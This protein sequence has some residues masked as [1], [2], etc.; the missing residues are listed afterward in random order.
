MSTSP[1]F[2]ELQ[3]DSPERLD[4]L[5]SAP[6]E[7]L[8]RNRIKS[9][10]LEGAVKIDGVVCTDPSRMVTGTH[11]AEILIP[12]PVD[13]SPVAQHIPLDIYFEDNH[14]IVVNK[15][16]GMAV[17]PAPGSPHGTL[18]NALLA[19][20]GDSLSGIG[21][22]KRPG[23]VHRIDKE[24]SGLLVV[25]K[26]DA[27]HQ[28]LS[29]LFFHHDIHRRYLALCLGLPSTKPNLAYPGAEGG[30]TIEA[31]IGRHPKDRIRQAIIDDGKEAVTHLDVRK[32]WR[33]ERGYAVAS[34]VACML[35]TGRTHQI[36]VH[37]QAVGCPLL[38]DKLYGPPPALVR[39]VGGGIS[40]MLPPIQRQALHASELGFRHPETDEF[41]TFEAPLPQDMQE[42]LAVLDQLTP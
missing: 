16:V 32:V 10:I 20:C 4:K 39:H 27:A 38:G 12:A 21:G 2:L 24:T 3:A 15:P 5:L 22:V 1:H 42:A 6:L 19:H 33:N 9:L 11:L 14:V 28:H 30:L 13:D 7:D 8:S 25:A 29:G 37:M 35:E 41:M 18:V 23:I 34:L 36:R 40:P 31:P 26:N 17:H